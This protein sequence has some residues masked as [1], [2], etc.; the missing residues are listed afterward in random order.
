M[1]PRS[2][3]L[4]TAVSPSLRNL[5]PSAVNDSPKR[6]RHLSVPALVCVARKYTIRQAEGFEMRPIRLVL[7][8]CSV[9]LAGPSVSFAADMPVMTTKAI[10][11]PSLVTDPWT[12]TVTPYAWVTLLDGSATVKGRTTDVD[13]G[14]SE[15]WNIVRHSEIPEDLMALMGHFE[16]RKGR[17]SVFADVV[18][19]KIGLDA[20]MTRSRGVDALN[21][22]VGASAGLKVQMVIGEVAAA[23]EIARWGYSATPGSG[24]AIDVFGGARGWWQ[25]AD[26]SLD[27][28][29]T[30]NL[31]GLSLNADRTLTASE[32]V[33]WIDP[34]VGARLRHQLT[35]STTLLVSGDVGGFGLASNFTWQAL[36]TINYEF[37]VRN[38]VTWSGMI[39]YKALHVD[40]SR[41]SGF[42]HYQYDMTMH[43]PVFGVTAR[44]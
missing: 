31:G 29:G 36:A 38:N 6:L 7:A 13:V 5:D 16:A 14:Y 21:A 12:F 42:D 34:L 39:G 41:G 1:S 44:F 18:Y 15:L 30:L 27:A 4:A 11:A 40:Y 22:S 37:Y 3:S 26:A 10:V 24:T 32:S 19:L 35:P 43:G 33:G 8:T 20:G 2:T 17:F 28:S 25:K 9:L 23:Y